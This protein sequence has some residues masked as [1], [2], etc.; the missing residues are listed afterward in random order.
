MASSDSIS[1]LLRDWNGVRDAGVELVKSTRT[2]EE[3][4]LGH[5]LQGDAALYLQKDVLAASEFYNKAVHLCESIHDA[6]LRLAC[7][8]MFGEAP[9]EFDGCGY[10]TV[11]LR[12]MGDNTVRRGIEILSQV[13]LPG[14]AQC[15]YRTG[16]A[17]RRIPDR[18]ILLL[19]SLTL[20][21]MLQERLH[22]YADA[23][24]QY[25]EVWKSLI[26]P[27]L[28]LAT[29]PEDTNDRDERLQSACNARVASVVN[30]A[31]ASITGKC[32][33]MAKLGNY[34]GFLETFR[35]VC[36]R[37]EAS[38]DQRIRQG[39]LVRCAELL[40]FYNLKLYNLYAASPHYDGAS[41]SK[42]ALPRSPYEEAVMQVACAISGPAADHCIARHARRI[43]SLI[44]CMSGN[45]VAITDLYRDA[46]AVELN[47][48]DLWATRAMALMCTGDYVEAFLALKMSLQL[49]P[50]HV[51]RLLLASKVSMNYLSSSQ[52]A[53]EFANQALEL[54]PKD[55]PLRYVAEYAS[56]TAASRYAYEIWTF[57]RRKHYQQLSLRS[58]TSSAKARPR[59][60]PVVFSL[61]A[62][63]ADIREVETAIRLCKYCLSLNT[64]HPHCWQLLALLMSSQKKYADALDV[65]NVGLAEC[66]PDHQCTFRY[67]KARILCAQLYSEELT[68]Q[69]L[70]STIT[71]TVSAF[72]DVVELLFRDSITYVQ[73][74]Q[75]S[76]PTLDRDRPLL[77]SGVPET[78]LA[79]PPQ[80]LR[81]YSSTALKMDDPNAIKYRT[82]LSLGEFY[83]FVSRAC[84]L[85]ELL[86]HAF[87][88]I[89]AA[90]EMGSSSWMPDILAKR[91]RLSE[92]ANDLDT[93]V[94]DY[95]SALAFDGS[96]TEALT[97]M[98]AI[99]NKMHRS[100]I[101][102]ESLTSAL[103]I[104]STLH[105]TWFEMGVALESQGKFK[106]ASEALLTAL[107]L[108][109][110]SPA[111]SF[112]SIP[113]RI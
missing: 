102:H 4:A 68:E 55:H 42:D 110:T 106:Q 49:E 19:Q 77:S 11:S 53:H 21:A 31:I 45:F 80:L 105:E 78:S 67:T 5:C 22:N 63:H 23:H 101:A 59:D 97:R 90:R 9:F 26:M 50:G 6:H 15:I 44:W 56:G 103:R 14:G 73:I 64:N 18:W 88:A 71:R 27:H 1:R 72:V 8:A 113:R 96:H 48:P 94:S 13:K 75:W 100:V 24:V 35:R 91:A 60:Q 104:D 66:G 98:G 65:C 79:L 87:I 10:S 25:V 83:E 107:E 92:N 54:C 93:A 46:I 108:E 32:R 29:R 70:R 74:G 81:M 109:R 3:Q 34:A 36:T 58:L 40:V 82:L 12:T 61:A 62:I 16:E 52:Q 111:D 33:T 51:L 20:R 86:A 39:V 84:S 2:S 30:V 95:E 85:T 57:S 41:K 7:I 69:E 76:F 17:V 89:D 99:H 43:L 38:S 28:S 112:Y 37:S 47:N